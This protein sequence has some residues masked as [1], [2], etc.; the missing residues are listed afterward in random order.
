MNTF[1]GEM[2][3]EDTDTD[4]INS[5]PENAPHRRIDLAIVNASKEV[6]EKAKLAIMIPPEIYGFNPNHKR[7]S[8]QIPVITRF[9]IKYGFVGHIGK[10]LGVES[11]I[12]VLDLA[13]AYVVLL[14]HMEKS[15][16]SEFLNNPYFFCENGKEFSWKE[17]A[18]EVGKALKDRGLIQDAKPREFCKDDFAELFGEDSGAVIGL[19]SR[20]RAVRL[21]GLGWEP[22]E[23]SIWESYR[24]DE[25]PAI[26]AEK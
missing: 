4:A 25:L 15:Q 13:R 24:E 7:L 1:E 20:S 19:N 5:L 10:G 9:A 26:L 16:P 6:S 21:R 11:Q 23:K 22:R 3:Y 18:E 12:H 8:I 17:V 14:H 2:I